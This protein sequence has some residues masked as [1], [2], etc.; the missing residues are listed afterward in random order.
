MAEEPGSGERTESPTAKRRDDF[1]K[2]GQVAQSREVQAAA[3][4]T[5]LLV[6]WL[7]FAPRF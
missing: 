6:F 5:L 4:F 3:L 1:R 2:K 7:V